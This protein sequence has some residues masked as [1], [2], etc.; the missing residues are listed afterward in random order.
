MI[1]SKRIAK[2]T[3][4]LYF[5]MI[6]I[7]IVSL[8]T[9]RIVLDK[10]GVDDYAL[11][12]VIYSIIGMLS[13]L[14]GTL[15]AGT[16]RF[17]TYELGTGNELRLSKTFSTTLAAHIVLVC[18]ILILGETLGVAYVNNVLVIDSERFKAVHIVY[19]LSI[20]STVISILQVPYT[21]CI[22]AHE[23]MNIYAYVGIFEVIGKLAIVYLLSLTEA[24]KLV[25]YA[26]LIVSVQ[27]L[28]MLIYQI[29]SYK[30]FDE[31]HRLSLPDIQILK[32][33]LKFSGWN[34]ITNV[35]NTL[36]SE[37]VILLFNVFFQPVVVAAHGIAKQISQGLMAFINNVRMAVNP[38][39]MK[40]YASDNL[41]DSKK[42]TLNSA[43]MIFYLLLL[44]GVPCIITM[45]VLLDIWLVEVPDYAVTFA[46]L[47]V[48]QNIISNYNAAF[49]IPML[50]ANK[51]R[52]NSL[53]AICICFTQ[54]AILYLLFKMGCGPLWASYIAIIS[55]I[56]FSYIVKP[57]ILW[58][59]IG[60]TLKEIYMS[61]FKCVKVGVMVA[62]CSYLIYYLL[63][64]DTVLSVLLTFAL[65]LLS[66]ITIVYFSMDY[67][68]RQSLILYVKSLIKSKIAS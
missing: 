26:I 29:V 32:N 36:L 34:I 56:L 1:D 63:P 15:S 61:V 41:E 58:R 42:L 4:F 8:Y 16:S 44:M 60:Y 28:V 21:A 12:N 40:L 38:Q 59:E 20:L 66:I 18:F 27:F 50:A 39:I 54:F 64:Q 3:L 13:F 22:I 33:I 52:T 47:I 65:S 62:I 24:D 6:L 30:L 48:F 68:T 5:R 46:R 45:P 9:S 31:T 19:Q 43:E 25:L 35:S 51:I 7:L 23:Q 2:N 11:Y 67:C 55:S 49:Y 37:G 10:L 57:L 17:L 53:A 14:T